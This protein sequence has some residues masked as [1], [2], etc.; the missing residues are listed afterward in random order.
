MQNK[1]KTRNETNTKK[2]A[3]VSRLASHLLNDCQLYYTKI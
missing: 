2:A 1:I 3:E